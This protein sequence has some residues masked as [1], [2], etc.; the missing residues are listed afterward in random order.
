[1]SLT[2]STEKKTIRNDLILILSL[3]LAAAVLLAIVLA[4]R[5]VGSF[6]RI[7]Q[8]GE[9]IAIVSLYD[10]R[11]IEIKGDN[12]EILNTVSVKNGEVTVKYANC[13]DLICHKHRPIKYVGES[14][15]C[16][17]NRVSVSLEG[18]ESSVDFI[19]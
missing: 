1:M 10:D 2:L 13:P 15:A 6:V 5:V 18:E 8:N 12:G 4:T 16:L 14:I 17:P 9:T 7:K 3:L 19:S 11:E